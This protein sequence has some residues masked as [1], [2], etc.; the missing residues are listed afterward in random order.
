MTDVFLY[1]SFGNSALH[2]TGVKGSTQVIE[3]MVWQNTIEF[4]PYLL[5]AVEGEIVALFYIRRK[6]WGNRYLF[7]LYF[8]V[9]AFT[10]IRHDKS[11]LFEVQVGAGIIVF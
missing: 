7:Q 3:L 6:H 5:Q 4:V 8:S 11:V 2:T 10:V 1:R 9:F